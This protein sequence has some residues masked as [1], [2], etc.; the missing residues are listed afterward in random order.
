MSTTIPPWFVGITKPKPL[1]CLLTL[2]ICT[3][4]GAHEKFQSLQ[5]IQN[6][7]SYVFKLGSQNN[8]IELCPTN[9]SL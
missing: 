3:Y 5:D 8:A 6:P 4:I 9:I 1:G 7:K 2:Y